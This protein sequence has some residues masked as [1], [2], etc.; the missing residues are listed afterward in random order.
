MGVDGQDSV[1]AM[2]FSIV[3][4]THGRAR[5]SIRLN[6]GDSCVEAWSDVASRLGFRPGDRVRM[7]LVSRGTA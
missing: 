3:Q 1:P 7:T 4:S 5:L 2:E 6:A